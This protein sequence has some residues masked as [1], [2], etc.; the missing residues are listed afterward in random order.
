MVSRVY[1]VRCG[2]ACADGGRQGDAFTH[3]NTQT[4]THTHKH[5]H[6]DTHTHTHT[7]TLA[8]VLSGSGP[9]GL[10]A[11]IYAARAGLKPVI[12]A[13]PMGGQLQVYF[14]ESILGK[15]VGVE[16]WV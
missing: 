9:A 8:R 15:D 1:V 13:P 12:A 4:H 5:T 3:T 2:L 6:K 7:H 11:A 16:T 14:G 10:A